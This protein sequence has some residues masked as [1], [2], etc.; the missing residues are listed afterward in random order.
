MVINQENYKRQMELSNRLSPNSILYKTE[1]RFLSPRRSSFYK[2]R[3]ISELIHDP[4]AVAVEKNR[5]K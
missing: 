4:I 2:D 3:D 1:S 5:Q